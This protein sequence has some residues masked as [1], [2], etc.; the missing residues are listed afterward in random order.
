M[1]LNEAI[2]YV[3]DKAL[4]L[5]YS[6]HQIKMLVPDLRELLYSMPTTDK[7]DVDALIENLF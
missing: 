1:T 4:V 5:G 7:D 2:I 6:E 3:V